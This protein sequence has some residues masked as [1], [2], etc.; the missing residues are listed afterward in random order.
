LARK[1]SLMGDHLSEA[2]ASELRIVALAAN[3]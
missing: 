2:N 1:L 3:D